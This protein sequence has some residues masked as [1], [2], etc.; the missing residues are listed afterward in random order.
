[1]RPKKTTNNYKDKKVFFIDV[2]V[3]RSWK[4]RAGQYVKLWMPFFSFRSFFQSHLYIIVYWTGGTSL[5]LCFLIEAQDSF[6][7]KIFE[8]VYKID[9]FQIKPDE[10]RHIPLENFYRAWLSGSH[11]SGAPVEEYGSVLIIA[12][13]IDIAAQLPYLKEL[14]SDFNYCQVRTRRIYLV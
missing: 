5:F 1:M 11:G 12:T 14:I 8:R 10:K 7:R 9:S 2:T 6:T 4:I 3:A 13:G